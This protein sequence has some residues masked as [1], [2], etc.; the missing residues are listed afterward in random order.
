MS[1]PGP[2]QLAPQ[3]VVASFDSATVLHAGL[4]A[5]L[6]GQPFP[7]L[8]HSAGAAAA[9]RVGGKLPWPVLRRLY[10]RIGASEGI[11]P[12]R[13]PDVDMAAVARCLA[14][15][16]PQ[17][18]YPAALVGSSN[19]ALTHLA[20]ALQVPWLPGTVL[21]SIAR[22]GDPQRPVDA[23]RFSERFAPG[24]LDPNPDVVLHHMHDQVQDKLMVARMTCFRTKW[25]QLPE[26]YARFFTTV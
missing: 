10:T 25:R 4:A 2:N 18:R 1:G 16:Y 3:D 14:D 13:L 15:G 5:A 7:H 8:G 20:A 24:L 12:D 23:L 9:V 26:A 21:V 11:D 6:R 19:G 22:R 17:R